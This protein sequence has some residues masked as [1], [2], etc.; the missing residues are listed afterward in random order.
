[1]VT[2]SGW[3]IYEATLKIKSTRKPKLVSIVWYGRKC[4]RSK[5]TIKYLCNKAC[6][7]YS[8]QCL[9]GMMKVSGFGFGVLKYSKA[10][11]KINF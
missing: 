5:T 6:C 1:M 8:S 7:T 3:T 10:E 4:V 11:L 2:T 9:V